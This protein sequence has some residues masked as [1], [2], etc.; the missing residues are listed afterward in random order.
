MKATEAIKKLLPFPGIDGTP[1]LH[2]ESRFVE[3]VPSKTNKNFVSACVF[4]RV[5]YVAIESFYDSGSWDSWVI[6]RTGD[7][8]TPKAAMMEWNR[9]VK[10]VR[11]G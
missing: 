10:R 4:K 9:L 2:Q 3:N 6:I 8:S 7:R 5:Y 11:E 1:N